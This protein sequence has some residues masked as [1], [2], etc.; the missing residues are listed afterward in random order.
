MSD[1]EEVPYMA[2]AMIDES[3]NEELLH[4][5]KTGVVIPLSCCLAVD[6]RTEGAKCDHAPFVIPR[7]IW[8]RARFRARYWQFREWLGHKIC[9]ESHDDWN[10]DW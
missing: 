9:G 10:D 4:V 5:K 2:A 7:G 6:A 8:Y 3:C 1:E